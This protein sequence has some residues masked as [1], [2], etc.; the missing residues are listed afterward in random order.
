M[1]FVE[2]S[3]IFH[4]PADLRSNRGDRYDPGTIRLEQCRIVNW[5]LR[6]HQKWLNAPWLVCLPFSAH[7]IVHSYEG[8]WEARE[9]CV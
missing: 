4:D 5:W 8:G 3:G 7:L 2:P 1:E 9:D 6:Q